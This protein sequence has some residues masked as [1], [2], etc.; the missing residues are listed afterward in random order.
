M[1]EEEKWNKGYWALVWVYWFFVFVFSP[2]SVYGR[3]ISVK[4]P[5]M[6]GM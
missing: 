1:G 5:H 3:A 2:P 6:S 4:H